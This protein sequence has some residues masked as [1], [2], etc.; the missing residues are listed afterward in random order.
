[1]SV[2]SLA[3]Y[4]G[5]S[6]G[7]FN[8]LLSLSAEAM[9]KDPSYQ[10]LISQ[11][12]AAVLSQTLPYT[13]AVYEKYLPGIKEKYGLAGTVMSGYTLCNWVLGFLMRPERITDM[14]ERHANVSTQTI[15]S[16]LPDLAAVLDEAEQGGSDWQ[17]A[18][19]IFSM[20]LI[21]AGN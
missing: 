9:Y 3:R 1:M 13:R 11:L 15:I 4:A 14:L 10:K 21:V 20:P 8:R 12:D 2:S 6:E 7:E 5:L 19:V 18:L 16:A 17:K